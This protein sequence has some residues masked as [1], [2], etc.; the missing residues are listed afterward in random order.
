MRTIHVRV[1]CLDASDRPLSIE[2]VMS[3]VSVTY[4]PWDT[5]LLGWN[6]IFHMPRALAPPDLEILNKLQRWT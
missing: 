3:V 2:I 4:N 6:S 5:S 1:K